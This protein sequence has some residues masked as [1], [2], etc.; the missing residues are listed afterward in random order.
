MKPQP[1]V[2]LV[3]CLAAITL[4]VVVASMRKPDS[5]VESFSL[6]DG[7]GAP[8][9]VDGEES[10]DSFWKNMDS[11]SVKDDVTAYK[12]HVATA[13]GSSASGKEM[14]A[15]EFLPQEVNVNWFDKDFNTISQVDTNMLIDVSQYANGV[16]TVGQS[17]KNPSYDIRGNI[18]NPK[19][20]ISPFLNSSIEPDTNIK[21][22]C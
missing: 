3:T 20:V 13:A 10:L 19:S 17:L 11:Q 9:V 21:S 1:V 18:P 8:L 16:D 12:D 14:N 6:V 22:W 15:S 2:I 7:G 5:D 4:V